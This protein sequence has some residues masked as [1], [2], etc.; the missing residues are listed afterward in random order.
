MNFNRR[1]AA[2]ASCLASICW[3]NSAGQY[4]VLESD[5]DTSTT[6]SDYIY[7]QGLAGND[8][9]SPQINSV[10]DCNGYYQGPFDTSVWSFGMQADGGTGADYVFGTG[11]DDALYSNY[12][13]TVSPP[14]PLPA[15]SS[16][17]VVRLRGRRPSLRRP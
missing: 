7:V 16:R 11:N 3:D 17:D 12:F 8:K 1:M 4:F 13:G 9:I 10:Y 6:S 14:N 15:D 2:L 5:C